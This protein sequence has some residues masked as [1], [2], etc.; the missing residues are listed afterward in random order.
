MADRDPL[1]GQNKERQRKID[2]EEEER[3][4]GLFCLGICYYCCVLGGILAI[5][6]CTTGVFDDDDDHGGGSDLCCTEDPYVYLGSPWASASPTVC[7]NYDYNC[8]NET[9]RVACCGPD[10]GIIDGDRRL[11][12]TTDLDNSCRAEPVNRTC[13][14]CTGNE[15]VPG[16]SCSEAEP[17]KK[18]FVPQ[19]PCIDPSPV[20]VFAPPQGEAPAVGECAFFVDG[21]V[22]GSGGDELTCCQVA[23]Q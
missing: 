12:N 2:D 6:L 14:A 22:G 13:G 3:R 10:S 11:F 19:C 15:L 23:A 7:G 8:D 20:P 16:W 18:R 4:R 17:T 5:I 9:D 21:C 1:L